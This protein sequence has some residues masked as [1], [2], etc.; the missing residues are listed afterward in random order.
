M[1]TDEGA[2]PEEV[3]LRRCGCGE[4]PE[5]LHLQE[6]STCKWAYAYG[7]CCGGDWLIEFRTDY[8]DLGSPECM[9]LAIE[10]WNAA[11]RTK[12]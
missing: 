11:E 10:A 1:L 5:S 4:T 6:G 3:R 8:K 12:L 2:P 9:K 7:S